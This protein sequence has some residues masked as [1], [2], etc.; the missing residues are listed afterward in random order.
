M[1]RVLP[2]TYLRAFITVLVV[3]HHA[4]LAYHPFAPAPRWPLTAEPRWWLAFPVSDAAKSVVASLI[5]GFNDIFFMAVMFFVSGLFVWHSLARRGPAEFLRHRGIRLGVPFA[6]SVVLLA[7]LAYVPTYLSTSP[8]PGIGGFLEQW[9]AL[10]IL[11]AGPAWFLWVLL[12]FDVVAAAMFVLVPKAGNWLGRAA[13][14]AGERPWLFLG[15]L[16]A[17]SALGYLPLVLLFDAISWTT[18]GPF[19]VQHS[20]IL[21]YLL[22]FVIGI[23]AGMAGLDTGVLRHDGPLARRWWLWLGGALGVYLVVVTVVLASLS[24]GQP[25]LA[26]E[27]V[28]AVGFVISCAV[29][30][31]AS[32]ALFVR[33]ARPS[34]VLD[35][36]SAHAYGIYIVHYIAVTWVQ[37]VLLPVQWPGGLKAGVAFLA[38]LGL[39]WA[40][41]TG[42]R[43]VGAL[44][45]WQI[46]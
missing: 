41:A 25:A 13:G 7:P 27:I 37:Y 35:H 3:L 9:F 11:P 15:L 4:V 10:G 46:L 26:W 19:T 20:R 32:I 38:A 45:R 29:S 28:T 40:A 24:A 30:S 44:T 43:R 17:G 21:H 39:S 16:A 6:A 18:I 14:R 34:R 8:S 22:Y 31:M 1:T 23:G 36:L 33:F 42:L 2:V 12:A 5:A